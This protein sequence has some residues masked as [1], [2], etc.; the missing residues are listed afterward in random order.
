ML[1]TASPSTPQRHQS[2]ANAPR[3]KSI[4]IPTRRSDTQLTMAGR[5]RKSAPVA[6]NETPAAPDAPAT[7]RRSQRIGSSAQKS[8]YFEPASDSDTARRHVPSAKRRAKGRP[9]Q[10]TK[11][12]RPE[13]ESD[14]DKEEHGNEAQ[15]AQH[16][17]AASD[18][19][20]DGDVSPKL[21]FIPLPKLRDTGGV[22]YADDR[23]HPNTLAFLKDLK[24]NNKRAWLKAHDQEYR[25]ALKDWESYITTLTDKIIAV[26][27]TIP[28]LPFKDVN[29]RI[30]RDIRFSHDP[31]PYKPHF[32]AAFSRTGRKGPY[33]SYY[34]HVEAGEGGSFVGGGLWHPAGD[35]LQRLR[36]SIDERPR[37]WRRVLG[38]EAF[39]TTF[40]APAA[41][42]VGEGGVEEAEKK[43]GGK[44]GRG[45]GKGKGKA[46]KVVKKGVEG[47]GESGDEA[48]LRAF[49]DANKENAL[50]MRPKGF[51]A[52][53]RDMQLLKLRRF[54]VVKRVGDSVFTSEDGQDEVA[55]VIGAMVGFVSGCLF[56]SSFPLFRVRV[57]VR[58][59]VLEWL[60]TCCR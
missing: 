5:K 7:R 9:P 35:A 17:A 47:E 56:C 6:E 19:A 53:H 28:E 32:A 41:P 16:A 34:V 37:R 49:A 29:F 2:S 31:T 58:V 20:S 10:A 57:R 18:D 26:D 1:A 33:A 39:R 27:P 36:A 25:R 59:R 45:K 24:A 42:A 22:E 55:G 52:E 51:I 43:K 54:V 11:I 3:E 23:L 38:A 21:T 50:K 30:Y 44:G 12:T 46:K 40:L 14:Q 60:L 48:A 13:P 4:V 15:Q 8:K